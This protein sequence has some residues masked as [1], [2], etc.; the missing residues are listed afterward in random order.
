MSPLLSRLTVMKVLPARL[1]VTVPASTP[2]SAAVALCLVQRWAGLS[3][4]APRERLEVLRQRRHADDEEPEAAHDACERLA[5]LYC[6]RRTARTCPAMSV[7]AAAMDSR[8]SWSA[9]T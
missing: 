9:K 6:V 5:H 8:F 7:K 4:P 2:H 3:D 1:W